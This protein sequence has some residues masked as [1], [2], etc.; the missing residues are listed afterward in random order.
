MW[1]LTKGEISKKIIVYDMLMHGFTCDEISDI[2]GINLLS[3][4]T[5]YQKYFHV[6]MI[7]NIKKQYKRLR[8]GK[9][10]IDKLYPSMFSTDE[11]DYGLSGETKYSK[12]D[13]KGEE[14]HIFNKLEKSGIS[15]EFKL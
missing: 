1:Y 9:M 4:Y 7:A 3:I 5:T 14:K 2:T 8:Y 10:N 12:E 6:D 11:M 15:K 13:F